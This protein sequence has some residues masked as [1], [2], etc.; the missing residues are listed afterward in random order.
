MEK[1]IC[2]LNMAEEPFLLELKQIIM[3]YNNMK[4]DENLRETMST[5]MLYI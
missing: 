3:E 5:C 1:E 4:S 2:I